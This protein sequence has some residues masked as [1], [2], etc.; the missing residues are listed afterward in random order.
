[1]KSPEL[2]FWIGLWAVQMIPVALMAFAGSA[3]LKKDGW[4]I[5]IAGAVL[6]VLGSIL[7]LCLLPADQKARPA[8]R[9]PKRRKVFDTGI[10]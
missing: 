4:K 1:M 6:G 2:L 3:W 10:R 8:K 5:L 7:A 9:Q